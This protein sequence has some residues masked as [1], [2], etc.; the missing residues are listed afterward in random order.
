MGSNFYLTEEHVGKV[1]RSE[2]AIEKLKELNPYVKVNSITEFNEDSVTNYNIVVVTENFIGL[3]ALESLN[4]KCRDNKV[5]FIISEAMGASGYVFLDYGVDFVIT[6]PNGEPTKP[7]IVSNVT[8]DEKAMVTVHEDKRHTYQEGD[9]VKFV[10]VEGM[11]ELN[12]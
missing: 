12:E 4:L 3:S 7:F 2:G 6:D 1:T 10:E 8:Q 5:G 11:T 9:Y